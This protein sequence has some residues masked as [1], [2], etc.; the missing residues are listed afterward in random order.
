MAQTAEVSEA[1]VLR[2]QNRFAAIIVIAECR[3]LFSI[4]FSVTM[5]S[6][7]LGIMDFIDEILDT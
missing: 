2:K 7:S 5:A 6:L 4:H 3:I 1:E